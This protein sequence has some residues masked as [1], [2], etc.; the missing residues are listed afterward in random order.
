MH[1]FAPRLISLAKRDKVTIR[2]V[3]RLLLEFPPGGVEDV[4]V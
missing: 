1:P 3:A 2:S 4:F